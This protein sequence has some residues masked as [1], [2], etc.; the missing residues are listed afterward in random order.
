MSTDLEDFRDTEARLVRV[1]LGARKLRIHVFGRNMDAVA[2][3]VLHQL[4]PG[5]LDGDLRAQG[6]NIDTGLTQHL[7]ELIQRHVVVACN[8]TDR[9]VHI[10]CWYGCVALLDF[11]QF[12]SLGFE[13]LEHLLANRFQDFGR[14]PHARSGQEE[15]HALLQVV[16][17]D[18]R[19]VHDG[20]EAVPVVGNASGE[21]FR[22]TL[23]V[24]RRVD[25]SL[26]GAAATAVALPRQAPLP[27]KRA[28]GRQTRR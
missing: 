9:L 11:E 25:R 1:A 13:L 20:G 17:G 18:G 22:R 12:D 2:I 4:R 7:L 5:N 23:R 27:P 26:R 24:G 3:L 15:R 16:V 19:V 28:P 6:R 8:V 14:W 10:R 21:L